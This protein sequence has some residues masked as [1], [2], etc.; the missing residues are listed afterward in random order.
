MV[1]YPEVQARA[2]EEIDRI[3]GPH[4]LPNFDD[5][6]LLPYVNAI[7]KECLRWGVHF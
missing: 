2:H 1:M 7:I 5:R 3:I 4:R 6:P